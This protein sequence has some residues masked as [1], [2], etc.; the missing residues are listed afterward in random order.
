MKSKAGALSGCLIWVIVF[1]VVSLCL[2]PVAAFVGGF[3]SGSDLAMR[4]LGPMVCPDGSTAQSY[5][6]ETT[7]IDE[8]GNPVPATGIEL[9]CV[10]RE[11]VVVKNDPVGYSFIWIGIITAIGLFLAAV[12]AFVFA[13]PAGVLVGRLVQNVKKNPK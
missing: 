4:V 9:H 10:D 12:F 13:A 11:G 8:F 3:S 7:T 6:Y 1:G 2:V 5:T